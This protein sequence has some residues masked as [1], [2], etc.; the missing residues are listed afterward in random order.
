MVQKLRGGQRRGH[1]Q[2]WSDP[3]ERWS[4]MVKSQ[5]GS[6]IEE[7]RTDMSETVGDE[8]SC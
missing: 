8:D 1:G 6:Q 4:E 3:R 7:E 5:R 2:G